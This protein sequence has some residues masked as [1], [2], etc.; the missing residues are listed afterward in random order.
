MTLVASPSIGITIQ[1]SSGQDMFNSND[2]LLY[3]R[4]YYSSTISM[5]PTVSRV[6]IPLAGAYRD[7]NTLFIIQSKITYCNGNFGAGFVDSVIDLSSNVLTHFGYSTTSV[8][9]TEQDT[10]S[11]AI[12]QVSGPN[13]LQLIFNYVSFGRGNTKV[14]VLS[15]TT[16]IT[17]EYYISIFGWT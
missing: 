5:G 3:K 14:S 15:P 4:G 10:L 7:A 9:I 12:Q 2:K 11:A 6:E 13:D 1:N 8:E 17:L 16:S